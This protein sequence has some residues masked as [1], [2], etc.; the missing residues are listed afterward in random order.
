MNFIEEKTTSFVQ[1]VKEVVGKFHEGSAPHLYLNGYYID[2]SKDSYSR[3]SEGD[4]WS[5]DLSKFVSFK[6]GKFVDCQKPSSEST[7]QTGE[8]SHQQ[9]HQQ[10]QQS[11]QC[12]MS[13]IPISERIGSLGSNFN[14]CVL[15][16]VGGGKGSY[17]NSNGEKVESQEPGILLPGK[18]YIFIDEHTTHDNGRTS[19]FFR[20]LRHW[21]TALN[22]SK[23]MLAVAVGGKNM[24][25]EDWPG[26][27]S[28]QEM[29]DANQPG[30]IKSW[31]ENYC[32]REN[33]R[34]QRFKK[35][36]MVLHSVCNFVV[37]DIEKNL[38]TFPSLFLVISRAYGELNKELE[39]NGY[40]DRLWYNLSLPVDLDGVSPKFVDSW[41]RMAVSDI[42]KSQDV[43]N[44]PWTITC[45]V[46]NLSKNLWDSKCA[47]QKEHTCQ[48]HIVE[49]PMESIHFFKDILGTTTESSARKRLIIEPW[50]NHHEPR[51]SGS[52]G[53]MI[54]TEFIEVMTKQIKDQGMGGILLW[55][56]REESENTQPSSVKFDQSINRFYSKHNEQ[57]T[58]E[59]IGQ[60]GFRVDE[61]DSVIEKLLPQLI[62]LRIGSP[63]Q[64]STTTTTT[65][66]SQQPQRVSPTQL[67]QTK[68]TSPT[69]QSSKQNVQSSPPICKAQEHL[70][71]QQP[72]SL[73]SE[74]EKQPSL[75]SE[76]EKSKTSSPIS[77]K[78]QQPSSQVEIH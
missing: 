65:T 37:W 19:Q 8:Q 49:S 56:D 41:N 42:I 78:H 73:E 38:T 32:S 47:K 28:E 58:V 43:Y 7:Q 18:R 27:F 60:M 76:K 59:M 9:S 39:K 53:S 12:D 75:V 29:R 48:N 71:A 30:S 62:D 16:S 34:Y 52:S 11:H 2:I 57:N 21:K 31:V 4:K 46:M 69:Q 50:I 68:T 10:Q 63:H 24:P 36:V 66:S 40:K 25:I 45:M 44:R 51:D 74:K 5:L 20:S 14:C 54:G 55:C 22:D 64:S 23:A 15:A 17:V 67:H 13:Y 61:V 1:S 33:Q 26:E 35:F 70:S 77:Q 3:S 6:D 72:S